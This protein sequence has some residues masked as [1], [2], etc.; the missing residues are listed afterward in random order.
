MR[1]NERCCK[2]VRYYICPMKKLCS[3]HHNKL[4]EEELLS[5][6]VLRQLKSIEIRELLGCKDE[7]NF[8]KFVLKNAVKLVIIVADRLIKEAWTKEFHDRLLKFPRASPSISV[9][10]SFEEIRKP[11]SNSEYY[12]CNFQG[13]CDV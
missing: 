5:P 3:K 12:T 8:V 4:L 6:S 13:S 7:I 11:Q 1:I 2:E 9:F 10:L